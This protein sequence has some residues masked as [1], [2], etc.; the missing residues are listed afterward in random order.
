[1]SAIATFYATSDLSGIR[2]MRRERIRS[3]PKWRK[4]GPRRDCAFA[5]ESQD[6]QGFHGMS[7]VHTFL[8]HVP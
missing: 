8:P 2:G 5:V 4:Y 7:V 6:E 1:H 3:T